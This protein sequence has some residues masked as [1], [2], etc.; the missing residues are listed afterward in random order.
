MSTGEKQIVFRGALLLKNLNNLSGGIVL[1]DEPELSMHPK[2]Q[3]KILNYYRNLFKKDGIQN[4]QIIV[5]THSEY[6]L[7]SA[8]EDYENSVIITLNDNNGVLESEKITAP[9]ILPTITLAE[10]NYIAFGIISTDYHNQLYGCLQ[11][12]TD[13]NTIKEC[14]DY[15]LYNITAED[16]TIYKKHSSYKTTSYETLSTYIRNAIDHPSSFI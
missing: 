8:L 10:T 1:I 7:Q 11:N 3:K 14:D 4:V 13:T 5:T 2:W 6:I 12:K 15:I 16:D 9:D